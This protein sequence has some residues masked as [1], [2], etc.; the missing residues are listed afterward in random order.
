MKI[1]HRDPHLLVVH[2][3]AGWLVYSDTQGDVTPSCKAALEKKLGKKV[4]PVHRLDKETSGI[5]VF[6]LN[7]ETAADL[8]RLFERGVPR[9]EYLA[10]IHG[11][12][13]GTKTIRTPLK[14]NKSKEL[15]T[16]QTEI[17]SEGIASKSGQ[18][19]SCVVARP[20]TGRYHQ[21]RRHLAGE[22]LPIIGDE[23]YCKREHT[24]REKD[25][26]SDLPLCLCA[27]SIE[28]PHPRTRKSLRVETQPD[29]EMT[30]VARKIGLI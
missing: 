11:S 30:A 12:W 5:L 8:L 10:L 2:K 4:W 3:P 29:R 6:A 18:N 20:K 27:I 1:L 9:K 22:G 7:S 24:E 13:E 23:L 28:F 25:L 26:G 14:K 21:I 17:M 16:A 15:V 19:W